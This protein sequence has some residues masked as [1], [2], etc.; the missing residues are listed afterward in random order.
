MTFQNFPE[1][2]YD[3]FLSGC[4]YINYFN[5]NKKKIIFFSFFYL[6]VKTTKHPEFS[7]CKHTTVFNYKPNKNINI[8]NLINDL[9]DNLNQNQTT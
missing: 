6:P 3:V 9:F 5:S 8:F 4:K 7:D 2:Y 1:L